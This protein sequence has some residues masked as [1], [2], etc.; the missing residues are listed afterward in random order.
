MLKKRRYAIKRLI[1][2]LIPI[3]VL[4]TY[5]RWRYGRIW[6]DPKRSI[7]DVFTEI[8]RSNMWGGRVGEAYS[9]PGSDPDVA[10]PYVRSILKLIEEKGV[11]SVVDIGCGDFRVGAELV[12]SGV[13]YHGVDVVRP[14]IESHQ[15]RY[16]GEKV[17]FSCLDATTDELPPGDLCLIRQV[18]QH[19]SNQQAAAV[20]NKCLNYKY[21]VVTE[22]MLPVGRLSQPNLDI[23]H[24]ADTRSERKSCVML[25][26]EPFNLKIESVLCDVVDQDG[27]S[28]RTMSIEAGGNGEP[29]S[30]CG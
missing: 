26:R 9:G 30:P 22:H 12:K 21:L 14:L 10:K 11:R 7:R 20:L 24:G 19:L 15:S 3:P 18:L 5:R 1:L 25:D 8:Y 29:T 4:D 6:F 13:P 27:S 16:G 28:I 2:P 17:R 23:A